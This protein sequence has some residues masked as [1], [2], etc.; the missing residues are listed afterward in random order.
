VALPA[1]LNDL[2]TQPHQDV[3]RLRLRHERMRKFRWLVILELLVAIPVFCCVI[4]LMVL[5]LFSDGDGDL[6]IELPALSGRRY[7]TWHALVLELLDREGK[8]TQELRHRPTSQAE[9]EDLVAAVLAAADRHGLVVVEAIGG[10][11]AS[12]AELWFGGQPLLAHPER[13]DRPQLGARLEAAGFAIDEAPDRVLL[14]RSYAGHGR[15]AALLLLVLAYVPLTLLLFWHR[16]WRHSLANCWDDVL[17]RPDGWCEVEI[18]ATRMDVRR[19]R[20]AR[21]F[22]ELRVDGFDLLGIT[23]SPTLGYDAD[24]RHHGATLRCVGRMRTVRMDIPAA[25][26]EG[27][28]LRDYLVATVLALRAEKP[29]LGL[30]GAGSRPTRC[31]WC[32][33]LYVF[34]PGQNCPSCSGWPEEL[35]P[36]LH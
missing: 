17:G 23:F 33:A 16:P 22:Q 30:S 31:P 25:P 12:V 15:L 8:V 26:Q 29:E 9:G 18:G 34:S 14:K 24:V 5:A 36:Q 35:A 3:V 1:K 19:K 20:G 10:E 21:V 2:L 28:A 32:S 11:L 13:L 4:P 27:R 6:F 7:D